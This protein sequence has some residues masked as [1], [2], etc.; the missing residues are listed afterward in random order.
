MTP[1][2]ISSAFFWSSHD[3]AHCRQLDAA[4]DASNLVGIRD[5]HGF[6]AQPALPV[7]LHE[8]RQVVLFLRVL[9]GDAP[10]RVEQS[11][12]RERVNAGI[13]LPDLPLGRAWRPSPRQYVQSARRILRASDD[14]AVAV[15]VVDHRGDDRRGGARGRVPI[16]ERFAACSTE[17]SGTSP[18]SRISV[19]V[20]PRKRRSVVSSA[21]AVPSC[22]SC[23]TN[24][25][26]RVP[27]QRGLERL[28]LMADDHGGRAWRERCGGGEHVLD[29]R[30]AGDAVQHLRPRGF[31][32]RAFAGGED[33][34]V[35]VHADQT[36]VGDAGSCLT[37]VSGSIIA[38]IAF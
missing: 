29:H 37:V 7:D 30:L 19:P 1:A 8:I 36:N 35:N 14:A 25:Q 22:G 38:R 16:D 32:A 20:C 24:V 2:A 6:D 4:V 26:P 12:E 11:L 34:D 21:C 18:E 28:G 27:R 17:S 13:D 3:S 10:D 5:G 9:R 23:T 31:H 15:R 33:D